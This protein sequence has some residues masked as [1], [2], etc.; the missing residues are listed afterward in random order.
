MI[1]HLERESVKGIV[2]A[3]CGEV[4]SFRNG[5]VSAWWIDVTCPDCR[6]RRSRVTEADEYSMSIAAIAPLTTKPGES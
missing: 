5:D 6:A 2:T 1:V 3:Q 4:V